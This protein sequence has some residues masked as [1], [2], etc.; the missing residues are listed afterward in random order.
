[1]VLKLYVLWDTPFIFIHIQHAMSHVF[2]CQSISKLINIP[3]IIGP[4][5]VEITNSSFSA[6]FVC[7]YEVYHPP[8]QQANFFKI[9]HCLLEDLAIMHSEFYIFGDLFSLHL[10]TYTAL[11]IAFS[12]ILTS[13]DLKQ[14]ITFS[15]H[16]H[17]H[18][19]K[20]C[21]NSFTT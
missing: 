11:I 12:E 10:N 8:G 7:F 16:I 13:F 5:C 17:R 4:T 9:S 19:L 18:W 3:S 15:T 14:H 20:Y 21:N 1:M 2:C 6:H